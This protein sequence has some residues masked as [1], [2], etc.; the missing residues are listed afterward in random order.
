MSNLLLKATANKLLAFDL[1]P[2]VIMIYDDHVE[3]QGKQGIIGGE[4]VTLAYN[5]IAEVNVERGF[6]QGSV[7]V[8]NNGGQDDVKMDHVLVSTAEQIKKTIEQQV[9][10]FG[11]GG[12]ATQEIQTGS[13]EIQELNKLLEQGVITSAEYEHRKTQLSTPSS[14]AESTVPPSSL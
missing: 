2:A 11:S 1:R 8:V 10:L 5:Q 12:S 4:E 13:T 3:F 14:S 6:I 7:T 9:E